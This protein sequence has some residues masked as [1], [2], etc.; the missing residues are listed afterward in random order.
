MTRKVIVTEEIGFVGAH[1]VKELARRG[2]YTIIVD[3]SIC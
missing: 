2:Y 1:L 3:D